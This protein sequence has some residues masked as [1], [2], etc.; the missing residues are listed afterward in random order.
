MGQYKILLRVVYNFCLNKLDQN[1]TARA[2]G[3]TRI[4]VDSDI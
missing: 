2:F 1:L 4:D 3:I